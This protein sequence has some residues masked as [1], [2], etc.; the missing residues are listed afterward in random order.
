VLLRQSSQRGRAI[1]HHISPDE[2]S[3]SDK[4]GA[5]LSYTNT[6]FRHFVLPYTTPANVV[7]HFGASAGTVPLYAPLVSIQPIQPLMAS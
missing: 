6:G 2:E 1:S 4:S 7:G 3:I 5:A